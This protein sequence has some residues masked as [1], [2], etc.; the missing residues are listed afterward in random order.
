M[1]AAY[2]AALLLFRQAA[3]RGVHETMCAVVHEA[4]LRMAG[5]FLLVCI[6]FALRIGGW[7]P[8]RAMRES[9]NW[10]LAAWY[11]DQSWMWTDAAAVVTVAGISLILWPALAE[12]FGRGAWLAVFVIPAAL[13]LAGAVATE[14]MVPMFR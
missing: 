3:A 7:L 10:Q 1:I 13:Y 8:W 11:A 6:G 2:Y 12:R 9:E 4:P 5:G 14:F